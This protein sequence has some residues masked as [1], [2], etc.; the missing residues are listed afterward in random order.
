MTSPA[1]TAVDLAADLALPEAL[2]VLDAAARRIC[3]SLVPRVRR[4]DYANP[5]L[6]GAAT[7]LLIDA[8][9]RLREYLDG[10]EVPV[11]TYLR[12][13]QNYVHLAAGGLSLFDVAPSRVE[14]DL[15]QWAPLAAWL[16]A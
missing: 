1:R 12:D 15:E 13:T 10:L 11:L 5:R 16:D 2:V 8:A 6:A 9:D 3:E 7:A 14:K 4:R